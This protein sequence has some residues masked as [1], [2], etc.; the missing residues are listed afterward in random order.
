MWLQTLP[1]LPAELRDL[2]P[3]VYATAY[4]G[5]EP[6]PCP[7]STMQME[8]LKQGTR[9]RVVCKAS[10]IDLGSLQSSQQMA[11]PPQF[12]QFGQNLMVQMQSMQQQLAALS[13]SPAALPSNGLIDALPQ[14]KRT[15]FSFALLPPQPQPQPQTASET[16][17]APQ[18]PQPALK[19][20]V[21][22]PAANDDDGHIPI[23]DEEKVAPA[24]T[25]TAAKKAPPTT[26]AEAT[27]AIVNAFREK[28]DAKA[29]GK[30]KTKAKA[31]PKAK[32]K[33][34]ATGGSSSENAKIE[35]SHEKSRSQYLCRLVL[36]GS[37]SSKTFKYSSKSSEKKALSDAKAFCR[38]FC[39]K[40]G[41]PSDKFVE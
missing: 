23:P 41:V 11:V 26:V 38:S 15:R 20:A 36:E 7:A 12:V 27:A 17:V 16:A 39:K 13:S 29:K 9:P 28:T 40:H 1:Q 22:K 32:A 30:A 21:A 37:P 35:V 25:L 14:A 34:T 5:K 19:D 18:P 6:A 24:T 8:Q 4:V 10:V 2:H 3:T 33:A 31:K